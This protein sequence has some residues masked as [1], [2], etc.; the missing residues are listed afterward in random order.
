MEDS[1]TTYSEKVITSDVFK[2]LALHSEK[3]VAFINST[4]NAKT[5]FYDYAKFLPL[6]A[7]FL[8]QKLTKSQCFNALSIV[9]SLQKTYNKE[10]INKVLKTTLYDVDF[11]ANTL[12]SANSVV[13]Y[14]KEINDVLIGSYEVLDVGGFYLPIKEK[15]SNISIEDKLLALSVWS[16]STSQ[17]GGVEIIKNNLPEEH[18]L[19]STTSRAT[20]LSKLIS[21]LFRSL[22]VDIAYQATELLITTRTAYRNAAFELLTNGWVVS[23]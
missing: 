21:N 20:L 2:L 12:A 4:I 11:K 3:S 10:T 16:I 6:K 9:T 8:R 1:K 7:L 5:T 19:R 15:T 23:E 22:K 14:I 17:K 18:Y 13:S